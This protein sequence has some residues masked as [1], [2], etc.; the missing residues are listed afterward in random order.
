MTNCLK[1]ASVGNS[2]HLAAHFIVWVTTHILKLIKWA[3]S[4]KKKGG[5]SVPAW[6]CSAHATVVQMGT[7]IWNVTTCYCRDFYDIL[8]PNAVD[9]RLKSPLL[10]DSAPQMQAVA[11]SETNQVCICKGMGVVRHSVHHFIHSINQTDD[12]RSQ[13]TE[14]PNWVNEPA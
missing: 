5:R 7:R 8:K 11:T 3:K 6:L 14:V 2:A 12:Y 9:L 13:I 1:E 4:M 10:T